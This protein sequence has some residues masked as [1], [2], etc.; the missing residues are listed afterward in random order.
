MF[1]KFPFFF[2]ELKGEVNIR[3]PHKSARNTYL[4]Y[5]IAIANKIQSRDSRGTKCRIKYKNQNHQD[6]RED[7]YVFNPTKLKS[8]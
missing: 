8:N 7:C 1:F 2:F 3:R 6:A 4:F 5:I